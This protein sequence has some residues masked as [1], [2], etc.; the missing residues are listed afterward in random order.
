M[1]CTQQ[2]CADTQQM[3]LSSMQQPAMGLVVG[4]VAN[5]VWEW[6]TAQVAIQEHCQL[7]SQLLQQVQ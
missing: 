1:A 3:I 6:W 5:S 7:H 4:S 2:L